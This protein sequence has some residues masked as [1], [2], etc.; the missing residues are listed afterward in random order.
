M[1]NAVQ[2]ITYVDRLGRGR[3]PDLHALLRSELAGLFGGVHL[4]PFYHPFDGA[5]AGYDPIDHRQVDPRLGTWDDIRRLAADVPVMADLIVNH[6]SADSPEFQDFLRHG[7]RSAHAGLFL[8]QARVFPRP[9]TAAEVAA[10]FSPR[11]RPPFSSFQLGD[12]T[13][14]VLWTTFTDKQVDLDVTHPAGRAY[15]RSILDRFHAA[16]IGMI[17][18]DAAGFAVKQA[19]TRC[20][21]LPQTY[22]FIAELAAEA[23]ALGMEVLIET[24][25]YYLDQ[26]EVARQVDRIY[27]FALPALVLHALQ[28]GDS[29]P[30][31]R[32]LEV[33]P[34]N[35]VTVLD[36]HDGIGVTDAGPDLQDPTRR[37]GLLTAAEVDAVVGRIHA[38]SGGASRRASGSAADNVDLYQ[39][40]CTFFDAL[41]GR[42]LAYLVARAIQF[43]VPGIPQVYYVG[44]LAGS[45]DLERL[46]R[47]GVGRDINRHAYAEAELAAE[48]RRPVVQAL[49]GLIRLR[50]AHPAFSGD[51][52]VGETSAQRLRLSWQRGTD[53][54]TFEADLAAGTGVIMHSRAGASPR[55]VDLGAALSDPGQL[56]LTP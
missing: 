47:T 31:R 8:T 30:L 16:G 29:R 25:G 46:A 9:P 4:L 44:L 1:R 36:T 5:D 27:D 33:S 13:T 21:M 32:W 56:A 11:G 40:N 34:R 35:A 23:R 24:H 52:F 48:L 53:W 42:E 12:G 2:L 43:F 14:E 6:V 54:A 15:L 26:L 20:F 38:D 37:P 22:A 39:V 45:N 19:G 28:C 17:R 10:I 50:N 51:F 3:V 41:G 7:R 49:L 18:L 55:Q